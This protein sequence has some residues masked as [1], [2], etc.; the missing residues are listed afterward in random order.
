LLDTGG[1]VTPRDLSVPFTFTVDFLEPDTPN[2]PVLAAASDTGAS[3]A[4]R[5]TSDT[6]PTITGTAQESGG[7]IEVY[8]GDTLL[9]KADVGSN[10][11]WTFTLGADQAFR[12]GEHTLTVVQVD[13]AGNRS[14]SSASLAITIDTT[15]P[16]VATTQSTTKSGANWYSLAFSEKIVF[17]QYGAIDVLDSGNVGRSHHAWD[18]LTN[19]DIATDARGVANTLELNLGTLSGVY[20]LTMDGNAI[21]DEAGNAAVIGT[22]TFTLVPT[23]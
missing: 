3:S 15:A 7:R 10:R 16:T 14:A 8:E 2:Q 1:N 13:A 18:V 23:A 22:P 21:Q 11:S 6:T 5:I 20:H 9:G 4:D 12:D 19:W 17:A